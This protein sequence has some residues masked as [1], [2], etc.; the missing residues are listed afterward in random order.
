MVIEQT[1][2]VKFKLIKKYDYFNLD[3]ISKLLRII[4]FFQN[5]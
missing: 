1:T 2:K 3:F 4:S 5:L